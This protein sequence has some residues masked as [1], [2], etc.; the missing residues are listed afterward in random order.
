[1]AEKPYEYM[2]KLCTVYTPMSPKGIEAHYGHYIRPRIPTMDKKV[3][4]EAAIP[5]WQPVWWWRERGVKNLP[6]GADG[7][8][9]CIQEQAAAIV[10]CV[11]AGAAVIPTH[12]RIPATD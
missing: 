9:T 3:V 8:P 2:K 5:G 11:K 4:I 12:P 1:M 7:G 6:P 10:E